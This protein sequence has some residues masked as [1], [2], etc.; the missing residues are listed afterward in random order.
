MCHRLKTGD[1]WDGLF[2]TC[3]CVYVYVWS[4]E[5]GSVFVCIERGFKNV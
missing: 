4:W 5:E 1:L 3:V 2:S